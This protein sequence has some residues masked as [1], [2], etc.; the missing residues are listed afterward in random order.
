MRRRLVE[1][2]RGLGCVVKA[3]VVLDP[4]SMAYHLGFGHRQRVRF[5]ALGLPVAIA[6][7]A[8]AGYLAAGC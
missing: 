6:V 3:E 2:Y 5:I 4:R 7:W 8:L 1:V